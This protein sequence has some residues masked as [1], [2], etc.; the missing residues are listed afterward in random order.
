MAACAG[1]V[2]AESQSGLSITKMTEVVENKGDL[3]LNHLISLHDVADAHIRAAVLPQAKVSQRS[4]HLISCNARSRAQ[5]Q[6]VHACRA[7]TSPAWSMRYPCHIDC[8]AGS[9]H[10]CSMH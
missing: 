9:Q 5:Q 8:C 10:H 1:S 2:Y 3:Q 7:A 4:I 6:A